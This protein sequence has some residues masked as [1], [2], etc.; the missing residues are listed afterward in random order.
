[1]ERHD[2]YLEQS[3]LT[4]SPI[5]LIR[6]LY[7]MILESVREAAK[8]VDSGDIAARGKAVT[9][10]TDGIVELLTCLNHDHGGSISQNL[11]E[12]YGYMA[13]RLLQGHMDQNRA[14][15]DE[16]EKLVTTLLDA[17][18]AVDAAPRAGGSVYG[19]VPEAYTPVSVNF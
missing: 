11:A 18:D 2:Q 17:W 12:L 5:E 1:L 8:C 6:T 15:F 13:S 7:R 14:P 9:K 16:V 19:A 3:I 4:A 10:A